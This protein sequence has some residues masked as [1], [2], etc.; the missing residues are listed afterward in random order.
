MRGRKI[1]FEEAFRGRLRATG[2]FAVF[3]LMVAA[4]PPSCFAQR[5]LPETFSTP[6]AASRALFA[7][8]QNDDERALIRVLGAGKELVA[9]EDAAQDKR[10]RDEFVD[11]YQQ[12]HRLVREPDRTTVL[13]IGAENWPFPV[14]LVSR[15]G[16]WSFDSATGM[17]EVLFRRIGENEA[18]ALEACH[19]LAEAQREYE[20]KPEAEGTDDPARTLLA[21]ARN[22]AAANPHIEPFR[23]H[24]YYFRI[25]TGRKN[26]VSGVDTEFA[27]VAYP[28]EYRKSGVM[29]FIV[30][31]D[32]IVYQ[33]DL[34]LDTVK[35]AKTMTRYQ[36]RPA[37]R[38]AE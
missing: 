19:A 22:E 34:G 23:Y 35:L 5:S 1:G 18:R 4:D 7:A 26:N 21:N 27:V 13:Y 12:M 14:P 32:D 28:V 10:E 36:P 31:K 29:T 16:T 24:G 2:A 3:A 33:K 37:W 25:L 8:V 15:N 20:T 9:L 38:P 17:R 6:E 30:N 11:K